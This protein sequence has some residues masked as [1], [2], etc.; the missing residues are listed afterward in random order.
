MES[1]LKD[2]KLK[3]LILKFALEKIEAENVS[4][5]SDEVLSRLGAIMTSDCHR[6]CALCAN[7]EKKKTSVC[8]HFSLIWDLFRGRMATVDRFFCIGSKYNLDCDPTF[9][10]KS[11]AAQEQCKGFSSLTPE[12]QYMYIISNPPNSFS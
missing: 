5:L 7:A 9:V 10:F 2:L 11:L 3:Y 6:L 4:E 1:I 12:T 8:Q